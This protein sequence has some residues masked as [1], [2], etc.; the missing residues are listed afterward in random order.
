MPRKWSKKGRGKWK[1]TVTGITVSIKKRKPPNAFGYPY[2][3]VA[4]HQNKIGSL[5][6]GDSFRTPAEAET[7]AVKWMTKHPRGIKKLLQVS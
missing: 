1:N 2:I 6:I 4:R 7:V 5:Q 3:V